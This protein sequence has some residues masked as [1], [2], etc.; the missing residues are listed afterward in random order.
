MNSFLCYLSIA[1]NLFIG[2]WLKM[3]L[4]SIQYCPCKMSLNSIQYCPCK[5]KVEFWIFL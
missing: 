5:M 3:S 2:D 1:T 4:N